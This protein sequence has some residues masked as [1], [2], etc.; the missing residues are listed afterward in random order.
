[1]GGIATAMK[2][3][4][5]K[6]T[7]CVLMI[8][9]AAA[10]VVRAGG[11]PVLTGSSAILSIGS[12]TSDVKF[13]KSELYPFSKIKKRVANYKEV[14]QDVIGWLTVPGTNINE[15]ITLSTKS[16]DYYV[17]R[18][19]RGTNYPGIDYTNWDKNPATATYADYRVKIGE[20]WKNGTSRNIV[21]YGHNWNNLRDPLKIGDVQGYTMFS[22]LPSYTDKKFAE[23]H[24]NIYFSTGANEG[25]WKVFAV[26]YCE[27][28]PSFAYNTPNP[29][30]EAYA[31]LLSEWKARSMYDFD[32]ELATTDRILTLS[33]C[34]R[35][36]SNMGGY[37]RFV[38]VAR[39][40][41]EGESEN[42]AVKITVN[43]KM[44]K[45]NF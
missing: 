34:T 12:G 38:V 11:A 15:P 22:Q 18:D 25:I 28:K 1:M 44:K 2:K 33:T 39:L 6:L 17:K 40:L 3:S 31:K 41:R 5:V 10:P 26:A 14:N 8:A 30:K 23:E 37:Q 9:M 13:T 29:T 43:E 36:Y 20:G 7:A 32:V 45:P 16:N 42:D 19:W 35:Q 4:I 21:L 24:P 27:L